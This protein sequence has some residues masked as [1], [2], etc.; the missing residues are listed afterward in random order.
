ME[1]FELTVNDYDTAY[2]AWMDEV[3]AS[4]TTDSMTNFEKME[5]VSK[6][7][8]STFKYLTNDGTYQTALAAVPNSP[9]FA[10][11][12]WDSYIS[13]SGLGQFALR[14]D[15]FDKVES[16]YHSYASYGYSWSNG[17]Y[18]CYYEANG[19]GKFYEA[20]PLTETGTVESFTIDF[21]DSS[22]LYALNGMKETT[23][24]YQPLTIYG[25]S[26]STAESYAEGNSIAFIAIASDVR[27]DI[28]AD[29]KFTIED[30]I[31]LQ[32]WLLAVP[33]VNLSNWKNGDL[34]EDNRLDVFDLCLM[35]RALLQQQT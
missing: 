16:L 3:I 27:G 18:L 32:K 6:Y 9:Y 12:R 21:S 28:N 5:A 34:M 29:G 25:I 30:V 13:P 26:G 8:R 17:H 20:C 14:I 24:A 33:G 1:W 22:Q 10:A 4:Q 23:V 35:K 7:L 31:L 2:Y 15:G 11:H 19:I